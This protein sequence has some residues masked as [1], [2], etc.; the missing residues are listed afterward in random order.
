[1][2][3]DILTQRLECHRG[4]DLLGTMLIL[5]MPQL[6]ILPIKFKMVKPNSAIF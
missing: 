4:A 5:T 1:M 2:M 6:D 3:P